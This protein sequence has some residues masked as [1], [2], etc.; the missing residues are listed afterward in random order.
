MM[1]RNGQA[2]MPLNNNYVTVKVNSHLTVNVRSYVTVNSYT[3][4]DKNVFFSGNQPHVGDENRGGGYR[5][6]DDVIG[7][8]RRGQDVG[9]QMY[10]NR[11]RKYFNTQQE[12][13][14]D[15]NFDYS[16]PP[17]MK[18]MR[19]N[20]MTAPHSQQIF[21]PSQPNTTVPC[22]KDV[23]NCKRG[24]TTVLKGGRLPLDPKLWTHEHV[25]FWLRDLARK[26]NFFIDTER[27]LM[28]GK[29][30]CFMTLEGFR[31]RS[32]Q[33]GALLHADLQKKL[34]TRIYYLISS[35]KL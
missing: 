31:S 24:P 32:P 30:L 29:G 11:K 25:V 2:F 26:H 22:P 23:N 17:M 12:N 3:T 28:N 34:K 27:F 10:N 6:G 16:Q 1:D 9:G 7:G 15:P 13:F 20:S 33:G 35:K 4:I 14:W 18:M 21:R 19:K 5:R 8:Y